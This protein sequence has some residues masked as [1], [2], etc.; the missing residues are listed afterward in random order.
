MIAKIRSISVGGEIGDRDED[1]AWLSHLDE[2][3]SP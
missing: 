1:V 3:Q 2:T